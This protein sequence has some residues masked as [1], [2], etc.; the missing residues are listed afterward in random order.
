MNSSVVYDSVFGNTEQ[1]AREIG[2]ALEALEG[3]RCGARR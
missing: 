3:V 1:V 2:R